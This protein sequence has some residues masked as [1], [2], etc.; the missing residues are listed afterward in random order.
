MASWPIDGCQPS[1]A[2]KGQQPRAESAQEL[3]PGMEGQHPLPAHLVR[4][5]TIFDVGGGH[6]HQGLGVLLARRVEAGR[7]EHAYHLALGIAH[8]RGGAGDV[9]QL[10]KVVLPARHLH[11]CAGGQCGAQAVGA[12]DALAPQTAG[13]DAGVG[14]T[15]GEAVVGVEVEDH[16]FAVSKGQQEVAAGDLARQGFQL[17]LG[18]PAHDLAALA[19]PGQVVRLDH[20]HRHGG[21]G[22]QPDIQATRPAVQD[23][24]GGQPIGRQGHAAGLDGPR[25]GQRALVGRRH[26]VSP[27]AGRRRLAWYARTAAPS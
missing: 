8:R 11:R 7:V 17:G 9:A 14:T 2:I 6:L 5:Q 21:A 13:Q 26:V 1:L 27:R 19:A 25:V 16:A 20:G 4:K 3:G 24:A 22:G 23:H 10:E 18:Q 15:H 12:G